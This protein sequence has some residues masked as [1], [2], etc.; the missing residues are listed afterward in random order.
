ML[1]L[2]RK[3]VRRIAVDDAFRMR[4]AA[5]AE[6]IALDRNAGQLPCAVVATAG[7][8]STTS[9]DPLSEIAA[10]CAEH[11]VWLHVDAAYGGA[12]AICPELRPAFAGLE[13]ADSI[14]INPHK[15]LFT[16]IDCS[17]LLLRDPDVVRDAY[18]VVP[19]FLRTD[20][21]D[22]TNLMDFGVRLGRRFRALKLWMVIRAFGVEG[23]RARIRAHCALAR[24][25][26]DWVRADPGFEVLAPVPFST[27]C[28]RARGN[29]L[30]DEDAMNRRLLDLVNRSGAVLLS[31][32]ELRGH[33]AL[34]L[35]IGNIRTEHRHVARAWELIHSTA[36]RLRGE[37]AASAD[38]NG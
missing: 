29:R 19:A 16:P 14:V 23:L 22:V 1:G 24:M 8:T 18:S 4:P 26:A 3:H 5:L 21:P 35:A 9:V 6:A 28:F 32:T 38:A 2:G 12:A 15:W 33:V 30:G 10:V 37:P 17:V 31:S 13:R 11:D 20:E 7:T 27:V 36:T 34:R 25:F